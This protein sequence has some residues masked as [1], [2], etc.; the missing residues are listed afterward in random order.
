MKICLL[1]FIGLLA[2]SLVWSDDGYS[3][4]KTLMETTKKFRDE[5]VERN[6]EVELVLTKSHVLTG[7]ELESINK[8][9]VERFENEKNSL[10]FLDHY[11][12]LVH[13]KI[14]KSFKPSAEELKS[15]MMALALGVTMADNYLM[16]YKVFH[17]NKKLRRL[18]NEYD[19][20]YDK[21]LNMMKDAIHEY[22]SLAN[23]KRLKRAIKL[24]ERFFTAQLDEYEDE[25]YIYL[26]SIINSSSFYQEFK[27]RNFWS[28]LK[29]FFSFLGT[30][31]FHLK[32][33][34]SD[35]G[36]GLIGK[37]IYGGSQIFGNTLG[38][39][40]FR[41][42][43]LKSNPD[44]IPNIKKQLK[45]LDILMERTPARATSNFIPGFWTHAAIYVGNE[46]DLRFYG[47]WDHPLVKPYQERIKNGANVIEA[48]RSGVEINPVEN[49]GE[50]DTVSTLR[51]KIPLTDEQI[52]THLLKA[53]AQL[54]KVYDFAF[55][56]QSG[57]K[58]VCSELHYIIFTEVPF[59]TSRIL[60]RQTISVDQVAEQGL[61]NRYFEVINFWLDGKEM[62]DDVTIRY[63]ITLLTKGRTI[64]TEEE[65]AYFSEIYDLE[66]GEIRQRKQA[67]PLPTNFKKFDRSNYVS[68]GT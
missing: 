9:A 28:P 45:V 41:Q 48:L 42:G 66:T 67:N 43:K 52:K 65:Q 49:F 53:F 17:T 2:T 18:L 64:L 55:D 22:Y 8:M 36:V 31:I 20:S 38:S 61:T 57:E 12:E 24:Y 62:E 68:A 5:I 26:S 15:V 14:P 1:F 44:F 32:L 40:Q 29:D 63:D 21:K 35:I 6:N 56:I 30:K 27:E 19:Q 7:L 34:A 16:V 10:A 33:Y 59:N 4:F 13:Y 11:G 46:E 50:A 58:I 25:E 54:G 51:I 3:E 47:I 37:V 60:K 23:R 39:I